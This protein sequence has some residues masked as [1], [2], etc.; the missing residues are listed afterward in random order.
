MTVVQAH[1]K[2]PMEVKE[3]L[4]SIKY[5]KLNKYFNFTFKIIANA[6]ESFDR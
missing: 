3:A 5:Y 2:F 6:L 4:Q 1:R